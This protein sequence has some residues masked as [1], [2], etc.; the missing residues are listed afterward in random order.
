MFELLPASPMNAVLP[1]EIHHATPAVG[2]DGVNS[3]DLGGDDLPPKRFMITGIAVL[4]SVDI[5]D[6]EYP[7]KK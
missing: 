2:A 1:V 3:V 7:P 4:S 6:P 5:G